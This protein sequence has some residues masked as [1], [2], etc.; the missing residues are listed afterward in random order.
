MDLKEIETIIQS[1]GYRVDKELELIIPKSYDDTL[2]W[3]SE[4]IWYHMET[5]G[6]RI[7]PALC[8]LTCELL[9]GDPEK[10][11]N[12][13]LACEIMHNYF[14]LHDDIMD[15][16]V[17]RRDQPTVWSIYNIPNAINCGDYLIAKGYESI[18]KSNLSADKILKLID[19]YTLTLTKTGEGQA[20]DIN[21]RA[22][23]EF[24]VEKYL[25]LATLKTG[26][27]LICPVVGGAIISGVDDDVIEILWRLGGNIG[28]S[29]QIRDDIIDLTEGKGRG[30]EIGCDI[31]E[32]KPSILYAYALSRAVKDE[33]KQLINIIKKPRGETSEDDVKKVID[34]YNKY[35]TIEFAQ[36][37]GEELQEEALKIIDFINFDKKDLIKDITKYIVSR[38]T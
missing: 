9:G 23:E 37:K 33:K 18:L 26:Y 34:I 21:Y 13:A 36:K 27:Y 20:L 22:D 17:V 4:P 35:Q 32:G 31:K 16:D 10:A 29:F 19:V 38:R 1:Y 30:G 7:R 28:T 6:K 8:L 14:L 5:G 11:I 12:F 25:R 3:L 15:G 2:K 24:T